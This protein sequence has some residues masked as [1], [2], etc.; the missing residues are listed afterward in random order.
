MHAFCINIDDIPID[1][2]IK[3]SFGHPMENQTFVSTVFHM[4]QVK[5]KELW[6]S[7]LTHFIS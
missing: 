4:V 1:K 6:I 5:I 3:L 7:G 2:N